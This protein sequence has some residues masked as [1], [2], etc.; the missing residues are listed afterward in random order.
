M[1]LSDTISSDAQVH[2]KAYNRKTH[3]PYKLFL[4]VFNQ[5]R[6]KQTH[7]NKLGEQENEQ[8]C[9]ISEYPVGRFL[10]DCFL[11]TSLLVRLF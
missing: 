2:H 3:N 11:K 6:A 8:D 1:D 9:H 10:L 5:R 4:Q 7:G